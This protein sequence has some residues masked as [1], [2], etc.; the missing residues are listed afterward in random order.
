MQL[1]HRVATGSPKANPSGVLTCRGF[2]KPLFFAATAR[3]AVATSDAI[4]SREIASDKS[5]IF[6][7]FLNANGRA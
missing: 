6:G 7:Q 5:A 4:V 3:T 1:E 2:P